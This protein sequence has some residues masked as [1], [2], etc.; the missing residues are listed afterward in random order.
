[1]DA[2]LNEVQQQKHFV[3]QECVDNAHQKMMLIDQLFRKF[4]D[5]P[6]KHD[7]EQYLT[8]RVDWIIL[9]QQPN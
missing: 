6:G 4:Q 8:Y 7:E 9:W 1:V 2:E 5:V 3:S